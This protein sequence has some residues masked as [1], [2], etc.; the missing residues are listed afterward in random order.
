MRSISKRIFALLLV[1][2]AA[3]CLGGCSSSL[4]SPLREAADPADTTYVVD[5]AP[6]VAG[7]VY[8]SRGSTLYFRLN[9][10]DTLVPVQVECDLEVGQ[11]AEQAVLELLLAGPGGEHELT[12]VI[13]AGTR[14]V[15][16]THQSGYL[17]ITLS[18]EFLSVSSDV[19][20]GWEND[21]GWTAEVYLRRRLAVY[22]IVNTLTEMGD[23]SRVLIL[24]DTDGS[25][26]GQRVARSNFGFETDGD[27]LVEPLSRDPSY[28]LT[29]SRAASIVLDALIAQDTDT[30]L[31]HLCFDPGS[32][33][34]SQAVAEALYGAGVASYDMGGYGD[35]VISSD[36]TRA[37]LCLD[38]ESIA[39]G[40][41]R[42]STTAMPLVA[43]RTDNVWKVSYSS[44]CLLAQG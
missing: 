10:E 39:A 6:V 29:A 8:E 27:E 15:G 20:E 3:S 4:F 5:I 1:L 28:I 23:Y 34:T 30:L 36:G 13:P 7:A 42:Q 31:R 41:G 19:P 33:P 26:N 9:N 32:E 11:T 24:I 21:P 17:Q 40:R 12:G 2:A 14:L 25:N 16:V 38:F 22:S 44:L 35:P 18:S 37:V 43:I